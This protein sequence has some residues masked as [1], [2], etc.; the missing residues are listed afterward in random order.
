MYRQTGILAKQAI[1]AHI[2]IQILPEVFVHQHAQATVDEKCEDS[3]ILVNEDAGSS[4]KYKKKS[5]F[6][7]IDG[8]RRGSR[9]KDD[10]YSHRRSR[11]GHFHHRRERDVNSS[12]HSSQRESQ[13]FKHRYM[14]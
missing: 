3:N 14:A 12:V 1:S 5:D 4:L 2:V 10:G 6:G 13:R 8:N 7:I 11:D 9:N